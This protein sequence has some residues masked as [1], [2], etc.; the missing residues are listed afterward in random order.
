M[1]DVWRKDGVLMFD[2]GGGG[3]SQVGQGWNL[4]N[5]VQCIMDNDQIDRL[6]RD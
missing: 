5:E 3:T 2:V 6:W 1:F 4:Y